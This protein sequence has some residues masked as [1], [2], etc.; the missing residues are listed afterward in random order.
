MTINLSKGQ[1][2]SLSKEASGGLSAVRMGLGW[3]P[4]KK[5]GSLLGRMFGGNG[6]GEIDLDA[7]VLVFDA[8]DKVIDTVWFRQLTGMSGAITHSGDSLTGEGDGDDETI[9]ID[10]SRLPTK[11]SS[12]VFTV[13]S[14][15]G[16]T[17]NEVENAVCRL[18]DERGKQE[19]CRYPLAEKGAHSGVV[20][21]KLQREATAGWVMTA[22]GAPAAGRTVTDMAAEI[23]TRHL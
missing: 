23:A 20:M 11:A 3:D 16:Q 2:I 22:I 5:G 17:F 18:V 4:V 15:R 10:L 1:K 12:L 6:G 7:S 13:N 19:I 21:A 14:F 9:L 8:E